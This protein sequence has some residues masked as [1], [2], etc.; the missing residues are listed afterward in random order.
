M[1]SPTNLRKHPRLKEL[2]QKAAEESGSRTWLMSGSAPAGLR[3]PHSYGET[4]YMQ[5]VGPDDPFDHLVTEDKDLSDFWEVF[6][7]LEKEAGIS[8]P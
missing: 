2:V 6:Y 1:Y 7:R 8:P 3:R 4:P 5:W